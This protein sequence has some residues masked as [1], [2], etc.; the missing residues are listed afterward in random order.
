MSYNNAVA[1]ITCLDHSKVERVL[2]VINKKN[3]INLPGGRRDRHE[4]DST[5]TALR[6]TLEET[7]NAINTNDLVAN[8]TFINNHSNGTCTHVAIMALKGTIK[9]G[10]F[11]VKN[12][13]TV[14]YSWMRVDY[15]EKLLAAG[16]INDSDKYNVCGKKYTMYGPCVGTFKKMHSAKIIL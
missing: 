2:V 7:N 8:G 11:P 16:K 14:A 3:Q 15:L 10:V 9:T 4:H 12:N 1:F 13:E 6:E 5:M